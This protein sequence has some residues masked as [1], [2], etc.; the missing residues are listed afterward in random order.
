MTYPN[1]DMN[2]PLGGDFNRPLSPPP[3]DD[4]DRSMSYFGATMSG[5]ALLALVLGVVFWRYNPSPSRPSLNDRS[6]VSSTAT[7]PFIP[8]PQPTPARPNG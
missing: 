6:P 1:D 8:A 7:A 2:R 3:P 5:L 4:D